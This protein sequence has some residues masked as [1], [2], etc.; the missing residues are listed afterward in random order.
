MWLRRGLS[1][2]LALLLLW[3]FVDTGQA[4]LL[5]TAAGSG[6]I[7][8]GGVTWS[9]NLLPSSQQNFSACNTTGWF[10]TNGTCTTGQSDPLGGT[11][12]AL[13]TDNTATGSPQ[14]YLSNAPYISR[15]TYPAFQAQIYAKSGTLTQA[16]MQ[17]ASAAAGISGCQV[18]FDL[19]AVTVVG[20][21]VY[22]GQWTCGTATIGTDS[23]ATGSGGN[24]WYLLTMQ[25]TPNATPTDVGMLAMSAKGGVVNYNGTS[26]T[27]SFSTPVVNGQITGGGGGPC[28]QYTALA[29]RLTTGYNA[30]AVQTA[31][32][33]IVSDNSNTFPFDVF[34]VHAIDQTANAKVNWASSSFTATYHGTP[35]ESTK[36]SANNG[37]TGD[38]STVYLDT[39]Y[40]AST[41]AVQLAVANGAM[42][43]CIT[44][45]RT[46]A[47]AYNLAGV[48]DN[49]NYLS[50][51]PNYTGNKTYFD[52]NDPSGNNLAVSTAQ[53]MW[54]ASRT[55]NNQLNLYRNGAA[56]AGS[57][58]SS[59]SAAL[60]VT[61]KVSEL[62]L[63]T[64]G[65]YGA[66]S[67]DQIAYFFIG[68]GLTA[69][70]I[71]NLRSRMNTY[72]STIGGPSVC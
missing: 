64:A 34:Y 66:F 35:A 62:A 7:G 30:A 28:S 42:G 49:T 71:S 52:V 2:S 18:I 53:G 65:S 61:A 17:I 60:P 43:G 39:G 45:A 14:H 10:P 37:Y 72:L 13:F 29:S 58:V 4:Y 44:T 38:G 8:A 57:P 50:I 40:V 51:W 41:N 16:G 56:V 19:A 23:N 36:F 69:T 1:L 70:Q 47:A 22:G 15:G 59:F 6:S 54:V 32:C 26:Q 55:V 20:S 46:A 68:A 63:N 33:G 27:V 25:A 3:A 48:F 31:I 12:A 9:S 67:N 5:L 24:G 21:S 11:T